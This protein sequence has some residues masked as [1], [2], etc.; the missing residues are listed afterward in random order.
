MSNANLGPNID[1]SLVPRSKNLSLFSKCFLAIIFGMGL[2]I[3]FAP[4]EAWW[5]APVCL[6]GFLLLQANLRSFDCFKVGCCFGLGWFGTAFWW[7]FP[8][9]NN[10]SSAGLV[11]SFFL[12]LLLI[13]YM[14]LYPACFSVT[15]CYLGCNKKNRSKSEW[16]KWMVVASLWTVSEW[17]RGQLFGGLPW[18]TVGYSQASGPFAGFAPLIGVYGLSFFVFL[19]AIIFGDWLERLTSMRAFHFLLLRFP[20][21]LIVIV[22]SGYSLQAIE[23]TEYTG[24][25]LK[26]SLL[27]GNLPQHDKFT[28]RGLQKSLSRYADLA[29]V[30]SSDLIVLP[31]TAFP[32]VWT[33][34][35]E[36]VKQEWQDISQSRNA[37]IVIGTVMNASDENG[38]RG[39]SNSAIAMFPI[40]EE[41]KINYRYD[42]EHLIPFGETIPFTM[43][44]LN[45]RLNMDFSWFTPGRRNQPPLILP[46]AKVALG[47]CFESLFDTVFVDKARQSEVL[48]NISNFAWF[49]N[50]YAPA[51][52]LQVAQLRAIETGRWF[53][54]VANT[55]ATGLIDQH[56]HIQDALP[57]N[58]AGVL[59]GNVKLYTGSTPFMMTKNVPLL[60]FCFFAIVCGFY[61]H[62]FVHKGRFRAS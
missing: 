53:L 56:G 36:I 26:V 44:W 62:F 12:T 48:L 4:S 50:T 51:Q 43:G 17:L 16:L 47:I 22:T 6:T 21:T 1:S 28:G 46:H 38:V 61:R 27:Q 5:F 19:I 7:M 58:I 32:I 35:P 45:R 59:E 30:G 40:E 34:L 9:L 24:R 2:T 23:W 42:K 3:S 55:G 18:L 39:L 29:L 14:A 15:A 41:Y 31:E 57:Q 13:G 10:Y 11:F 49:I 33:A 8:G 54:Q 52:H 20:V 37:A 25:D 60:F